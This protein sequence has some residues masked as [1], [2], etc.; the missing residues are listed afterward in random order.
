MAGPGYMADLDEATRFLRLASD[1]CRLRVMMALEAGTLRSGQ[2]CDVVGTPRAAIAHHLALLR[3]SG[4]VQ[5]EHVGKTVVYSLSDRG[6]AA[7]AGLLVTWRALA[8]YGAGPRPDGVS[9]GED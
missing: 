1:P 7:V 8:G 6:R 5:A 2:L 3:V 4:V 9:N